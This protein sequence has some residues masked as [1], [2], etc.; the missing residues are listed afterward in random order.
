MTLYLRYVWPVQNLNAVC[1]LQNMVAAVPAS[2][3]GTLADPFN[4]SQVSFIKNGFIRNVSITSANNLSAN[5]FTIVGMQNGVSITENI[6][7]PNNNTVYG[8][9]SYDVVLSITVN[10]NSNGVEIGT[11]DRGYLPLIAVDTLMD[12]GML[13]Y[14]FQVV[15]GPTPAI[16]YDVL[17][18]LVEVESSGRTYQDLILNT[19]T[20]MP[21][22]GNQT[23]SIIEQDY[24]ITKHFLLNITASTTPATDTLTF[25]Y[26]Q[27]Q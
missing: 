6:T 26:I 13:N 18:T 24:L 22:S 25:I 2:L 7:G 11:G 3:N 15:L 23:T 27:I 5:T 8:V 21:F 4:A 14:A 19:G 10:N 9:L 20:F 12:T 17:Y 1:N 16:T